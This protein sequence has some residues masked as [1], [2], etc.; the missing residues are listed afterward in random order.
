MDRDRIRKELQF[1]LDTRAGELEASGVS[2]T[3]ARRRAAAEF[4]LLDPVLE[5]ARDGR[6]LRWARDAGRDLRFALR[7]WRR[8]PGFAGLAVVILALGIG[9]NAV[10]FGLVQATLLRPLPY[11]G[12]GGDLVYLTEVDNH[13]ADQSFSIPDY[14]DYQKLSVFAGFGGYRN[15]GFAFQHDGRTVLTAARLVTAGML[16]TLGVRPALGRWFNVH[17]HQHNGPPV[18]I[19]SDGF[20]RG[21]LGADPTAV[22]SVLQTSAGPVTVV[23]VMP[24][25]FQ[26]GRK[27]EVWSP[28]E[29]TVPQVYFNDRANS[30]VLYCMGRLK[31][32]V[33]LAQAKAAVATLSARLAKAYPASNLTVHGTIEPLADKLFGGVRGSL[34]MLFAAVGAVLLIVCAN[35]ANLL[36]ARAAGRKQEMAVRTAIGAGRARLARQLLAEGMLLAG[37]GAVLG[38][39]L[40]W[41]GLRGIAAGLPVTFPIHGTLGLGSA[42]VGY[43]LALAVG[44][45]LLFSLAPILMALRTDLN[46]G[47]KGADRG[48]SAARHRTHNALVVAEVAMAMV[49]LAAA[50][51]MLRSMQALGRVDFGFNP[52][53]LLATTVSLSRDY[54]TP[55]QVGAFFQKLQGQ[56]AALPGVQSAAVVFPVPFTFQVADGFMA[57]EG[58][59]PDPNAPLTSHYAN[60]DYNYFHTMQMPLLAGRLL[61][62]GDDAATATPVVVI[63]RSLADQYW[64]SPAAAVGKRLQFFT[65]TFGKGGIPAATIVGVVGEIKA[66]A[67][68]AN[69]NR[70][71]YM[72]LNQPNGGM[73]LVMRYGGSAA[74]LG[75]AVQKLVRQL[76]PKVVETPPLTVDALL[77]STQETRRLTMHLLAAFS[78]AALLLALLGLYGVLSYLIRQRQRE[79]G[80]R[81]ALGA[82]QR[83]VQ[84]MVLRQGLGLCLVGLVLGGGLALLLGR[85][86]NTLLFGVRARDPL[87][88]FCAAALLVLAAGLACYIPAR[89]A[90]GLDPLPALRSE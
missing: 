23:G 27:V 26:F 12:G 61:R 3:E 53:H 49:L 42:I 2:A 10:M 46:G 6:A 25:S 38:L 5:E 65:Q 9:A 20:W 66:T 59:A 33:T 24:P 58:R 51:L 48:Q 88:F 79:I 17:E 40:A 67:A 80:I 21:Y 85:F 45:G 16:E 77:A 1:H 13:G 87:T 31:P 62:P 39:G 36:L 41:L 75:S 60:V 74:T 4:G 14:L 73:T 52:D 47:L 64:G 32:E 82:S 18:V 71:V 11:R 50:G 72:P 83:G 37:A 35:L 78:L 30:F 19:V 70:E 7:S 86:L 34:W 68:D 54:K 56:A 29:E 81:I 28:Y 63:D 15:L 43:S 90:A 55:A 84:A 76:D 57:I 89:R 22:G 44:T 69:A 8:S